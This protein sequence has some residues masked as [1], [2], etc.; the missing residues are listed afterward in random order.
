MLYLKP[1]LFDQLP[2]FDAI[3][4]TVA[5]SIFEQEPALASLCFN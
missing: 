2:R 4:Q 3:F 1:A 5:L